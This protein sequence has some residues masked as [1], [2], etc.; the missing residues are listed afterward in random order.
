VS[1]KEPLTR[2]EFQHWCKNDFKHLVK[3]VWRIEGILYVLVPLVLAILA[4]VLAV[5]MR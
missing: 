2:E 4:A 1:N 5:L 3:K